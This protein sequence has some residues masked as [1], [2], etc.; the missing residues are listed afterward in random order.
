MKNL[1]L[2]S[3][4]FMSLLF[5]GFSCSDDDDEI[6]EPTISS[7]TTTANVVK[8]FTSITVSGDV[9]SDGG[10]A[11]TARGVAWG[12]NPNPTIADNKTEELSDSFTSEISGLTV[13]TQYYFRVY[14]TNSVGT[15]YSAE[16][17]FNTLSLAGTTWDFDIRF[18]SSSGNESGWPA[19]VIFYADGTTYYDEL[20][21]PGVYTATG[22]WSL[23]GN[24]LTFD[25]DSSNTVL[26]GWSDY[27]GDVS[28][29]SMTGTWGFTSNPGSQNWT[30]E[31]R[32]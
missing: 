29:N 2:K 30:A 20:D 28:G 19:E 27:V 10:S 1:I 23:D 5:L 13:N 22:T 17:T 12:T 25:P 24:E 32:D 4:L 7:T 16:Q 18:V 6:L 9:T 3:V 8:T 11:I 15:V 14:A 26:G 31:I 21:S